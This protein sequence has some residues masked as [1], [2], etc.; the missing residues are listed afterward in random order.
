LLC[1]IIHSDKYNMQT[2]Q[3]AHQLARLSSD[4]NSQK[5]S[6]KCYMHHEVLH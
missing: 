1:S 4:Q 2:Q 3:A 5:A 6:S